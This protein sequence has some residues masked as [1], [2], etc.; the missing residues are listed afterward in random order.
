VTIPK[1]LAT[2]GIWLSLPAVLLGIGYML[3]SY[4]EGWPGVLL[5]ALIAVP[6]CVLADVLLR[7][8]RVTREITHPHALPR[9]KVRARAH[10]ASE[11]PGR[12]PLPARRAQPFAWGPSSERARRTRL[13]K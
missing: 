5:W 1:T 6:L 4:V 10:G 7:R 12:R 3:L 13:R 11:P 2:I 9:L 8:Q